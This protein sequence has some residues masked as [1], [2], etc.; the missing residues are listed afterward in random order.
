MFI[1]NIATHGHIQH[2]GKT[3]YERECAQCHG[4]K[5]EGIQSLIPPLVNSDFAIQN[6]DSIPCWIKN[7]IN[8]PITVNGKEYEQP[9]YGLKIDEIETGNVINYINSEFLHTERT[10]NSAWVKAQWQNCDK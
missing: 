9:M 4:D 6:F 7:G 10:I 2:P 5:G 1:Y 3:T 8:R